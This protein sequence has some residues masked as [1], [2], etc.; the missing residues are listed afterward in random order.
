MS[1]FL[2]KSRSQG[3]DTDTEMDILAQEMGTQPAQV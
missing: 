2:S 1:M 3:M